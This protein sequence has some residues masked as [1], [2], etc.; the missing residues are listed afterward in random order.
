MLS[1]MAKAMVMTAAS[2]RLTAALRGAMDHRFSQLQYFR[3]ISGGETVEKRTVT[4]LNIRSLIANLQQG[5]D[6]CVLPFSCLL[7]VDFDK[8]PRLTI[9]RKSEQPAAPLDAARLA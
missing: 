6:L 2:E 8:C 7:E 1:P 5:A 9:E 4:R 3:A